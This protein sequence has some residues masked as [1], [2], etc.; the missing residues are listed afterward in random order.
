MKYEVLEPEIFDKI[1]QQF[2]TNAIIEVITDYFP[3]KIRLKNM[4]LT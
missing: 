2:D 4:V 3:K 1:F